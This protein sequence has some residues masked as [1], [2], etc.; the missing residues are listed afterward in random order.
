MNYN[1][2]QGFYP[3][4]CPLAQFIRDARARR[5]GR[6]GREKDG[7]DGENKPGMTGMGAQLGGETGNKMP[8]TQC[9]RHS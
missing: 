5:V 1:S 8:S 9:E 3:T 2:L 7:Q 6:A 4:K